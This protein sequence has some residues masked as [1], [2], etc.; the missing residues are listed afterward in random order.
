MSDA[1]V[2]ILLIIR[3][4]MVQSGKLVPSLKGEIYTCGDKTKWRR[5]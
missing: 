2:G 4:C 1:F 5:V 3:K